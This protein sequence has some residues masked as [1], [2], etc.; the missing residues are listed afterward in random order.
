MFRDLL[1]S[2]DPN[3]SAALSSYVIRVTTGDFRGAG[4]DADVYVTIFGDLGDT[5]QKFLD[6]R[7]ENNFERN[8]TDTFQLKLP[9]VG[10]IEK[11]RIGHNNKGLVLQAK[12]MTFKRVSWPQL[13]IKKDLQIKNGLQL[14]QNRNDNLSKRRL[15]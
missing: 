5:G 1:G 12:K 14:A 7:M 4:T 11:I 10:E 3:K 9:T 2:R 6:N 13:V 8:R 15:F